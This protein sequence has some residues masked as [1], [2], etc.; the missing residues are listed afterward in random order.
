[1]FQ[2]NP[3]FIHDS[4]YCSVILQDFVLAGSFLLKADSIV[5]KSPTENSSALWKSRSDRGFYIYGDSFVDEFIVG[6]TVDIPGDELE[7][8]VSLSFKA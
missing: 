5:S 4:S 7:K 3:K 2:P 1:M 8:F 6:S